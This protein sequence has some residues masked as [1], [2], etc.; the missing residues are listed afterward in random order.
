MCLLNSLRNVVARS[1]LSERGTVMMAWVGVD[2]QVEPK[3]HLPFFEKKY[4]FRRTCRGRH[5]GLPERNSIEFFV[6]LIVIPIEMVV[7]L[8]FLECKLKLQTTAVSVGYIDT[9]AM[10]LH[11][12]LHNCK[13]KPGAAHSARAPFVNAVESLEQAR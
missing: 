9:A 2:R 6:A 4:P 7:S 12:M 3:A 11:G 10:E 5:I 8:L 1:S 13:A